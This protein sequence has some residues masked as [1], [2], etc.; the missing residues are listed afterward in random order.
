[1]KRDNYFSE[2]EFDFRPATLATERK[3]LFFTKRS[4][5]CEKENTYFSE[6][7]FDFR[8]AMLASMRKGLEVVKMDN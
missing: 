7:E 8:P 2:K 4:P 5:C 3:E 1:M 6:R